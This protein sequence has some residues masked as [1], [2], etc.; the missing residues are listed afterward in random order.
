MVFCSHGWVG[1]SLHPSVR[2][3]P[4]VF[5]ILP[6]PLEV[7]SPS[8]P[9]V[10]LHTL[11]DHPCLGSLAWSAIA[12]FPKDTSW[13]LPKPLRAVTPPGPRLKISHDFHRGL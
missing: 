13:L 11:T 8:K 4:V 7:S 5:S 12:L 9:S 6:F 2:E 10:F 1:A 3:H